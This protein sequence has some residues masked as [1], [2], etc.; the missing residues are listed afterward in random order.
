M[1]IAL[2]C[3]IVARAR[4][5][6]AEFAVWF[7]DPARSVAPHLDGAHFSVRGLSDTG[8]PSVWA[9]ANPATVSG[10]TAS[11]AFRTMECLIDISS[12]WLV[13]GQVDRI[14]MRARG[15]RGAGA[16]IVDWRNSP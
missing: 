6:F 16:T 10:I 8:P 2:F 9:R 14:P 4:A 11:T 12:V 7:A 3:L 13:G 1:V 5:M 15:G